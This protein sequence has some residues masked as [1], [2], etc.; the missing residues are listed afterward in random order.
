MLNQLD[1]F[2]LDLPE[3]TK[4]CMLALRDIIL[5]LSDEIQPAWK[6]KLPFFTYKKK[7][8]CYLWKEKKN[9][10]PYIGLPDGNKINHPLLIQGDRKRMKILLIDPNKDIP[11][12]LIC[13]ILTEIMELYQ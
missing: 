3:P 12:E 11:V 13:V 5:G 1:N 6:Y 7:N 8:L 4:S 10:H 9:N 2:Y